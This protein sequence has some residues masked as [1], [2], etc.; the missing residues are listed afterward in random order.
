MQRI[1]YPTGFVHRLTR[2]AACA[3]AS[4]FVGCYAGTDPEQAGQL[5]G[6]FEIRLFEAH[7]ATRVFGRITKGAE[8]QAILWHVAEQD[9]TC[10]LLE[11]EAPFCEVPCGSGAV[12]TAENECTPYPEASSVGSVY[13]SGLSKREIEMQPEDGD[14]EPGNAELAFPPCAK[15]DAI[16]LRADGLDHGG[17][18]LGTRCI[19]PL[20]VEIPEQ[21][22]RGRDLTLRWSRP[23]DPDLAR[24][25]VRVSLNHFGGSRGAI[26]CD[27]DDIGALTIPSALVDGLLQLGPSALPTITLTRL[28]RS[29]RS[30]ELPGVTL[31]MLHSIEHPLEIG[32]H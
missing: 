29:A 15:G 27:A 9:G 23:A 26:E 25:R 10:D 8:P 14:Y 16:G 32:G 20:E 19:E 22:A 28:A 6:D 17:F 1:P 5:V 30:D 12:S 24:L 4:A 2:L 18:A 21:L 3:L 7:L 13:V 31:T 11:P